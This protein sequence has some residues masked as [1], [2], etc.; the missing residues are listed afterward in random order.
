MQRIRLN[1]EKNTGKRVA[2][3]LRI[4]ALEAKLGNAEQAWEAYA[5]AFSENPE[6][7]AARE[8]LENLA[9]ILDNWAPLVALYE[10]ALGG[11]KKLPP[12]L[13]RELLLVVAVA[14]DEK[15]DK[16]EKAVEYFRRAQTIQPEDA[17]ALVAL[18]RLYTRTERW[19]DLIDTLT[20]K[21][22]L[23][24]DAAEREQIR[25]RI[26]TVWEEMLGNADRGDRGLER[27]AEGQP[28]QH[29]GAALARSAVP[30]RRRVPRAGRQPA[31]P[32]GAGHRSA[33][34]H[35]APGAARNLAR[36]AA[37]RGGRRGR[38][39]P[40]DPRARARARRDAGGAGAHPPGPRARAAG[41]RSCWSRSTR[42]AATG[43]ASS[44][45]TRSRRGT[46]SI[47]SRRSP[48]TSRSPTVTR[49]AWTIP[50]HAYEALA[51]ALREDPQNPEVQAAIERLARALRQAGRSGGSLRTDGV[52]GQRPYA[53]ERALSQDRASVRGRPRARPAGGGGL[54]GGAG[55]RRRAISTAA[56][57]LEQ[58]YLRRGDYASLVEL[59]LRKADIV[60]GP[61][62]KKELY[63]KAAQLYEEVLE[64][65]EKAIDV[66]RQVLTIDETDGVALDNL[67]RLYIRLRRWDDLKDIYG[68]KAEL[69]QNPAEKKQM[70][71]VLGQV[72]DRE[73]DDPERAIE[74]YTS[75]MDLDPD[76]FDAAQAL[77]RLYLQTER[78]YDLLAVLERQTELAPSPAEVVSLRFRIG[79][80]WREHLKDLTRAVEAYRQVLAMDPAHEPTLRALEALMA[81]RDEPV[82]AAA[83]LE[84]IYEAAGEWD[85]VIAVYEVMQANSDDALRRVEL[86]CRIAE[87]EERR[88]SHQNAAFEAYGR[89]LHVDPSNQD[90]IAHLRAAGG[91]DRAL[92]QAGRA[93]R[94]GAGEDR[95][96]APPDR[97]AGCAWRASTRRRPARPTTPSP[98]TGGSSSPSPTTRTRWWR[99]IGST[100]GRSSGKS[101]P[102]S[103]GARSGSRPTIAPSS[104]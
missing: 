98:P 78:W 60:D 52:V 33:G 54:R 20:K 10:A 19:P 50:E 18:E 44:R 87:I 57:A 30:A 27:G 83:V 84:P 45:S 70:L 8:A 69:A 81:G 22:Q 29:P 80:L 6:S 2:L 4:G 61:D 62:E 51:R 96:P 46:R 39:L 1:Q 64:N 93:V 48:S 9:S 65:L 34:D 55:G 43:R 38:D 32:A 92:A 72:Y 73:L 66:F 7:S 36:A 40:P 95:R 67:E 90:V 91:R 58:L 68:K 85:R 88:L 74:T 53:E 35:R 63:Y 59:L 41:R 42:P 99:W 79:E 47:P 31:A 21:A 49:S 86:L 104:T 102:T 82:L 75:I 89:A 13:E 14:Y 77:D 17:S 97:D 24:T 26:A 15:L 100:A 25:T 37:R 103:C 94:G 71:F 5:K 12:A 56:N 3:L 23:V 28:R 11:K 76:D 16:S 101:W